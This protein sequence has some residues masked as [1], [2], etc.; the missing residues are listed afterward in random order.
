MGQALPTVSSAVTIRSWESSTLSE[1]L[2]VKSH[3]W[4]IVTT[5][6]VI[7]VV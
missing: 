7:A 2:S 6:G 3:H 4:M 1:F 5:V